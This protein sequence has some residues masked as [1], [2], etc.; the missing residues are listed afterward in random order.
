MVS[1]EVFN[2]KDEKVAEISS[3]YQGMGQFDLLPDSGKYTAKVQYN[4]KEYKFELPK[5]LL[6]GYVM[7]VD[8]LH[9]DEVGIQIESNSHFAGELLGISISS[10]GVL[11]GSQQ[12][13]MS[14][15]HAASFTF[16]KKMLPSGVSQI[17]LFNAVGVVLSERLIFVNH[18]SQMKMEMSQSKPIYR[19]FE[20]VNLDFKLKDMRGN[21]VETT[22]SVA[23]RDA[24]TSTTN[25]YGNNILTDL[26]LSSEV[27][28]YIE[29]PEYYFEKEN[30]THRMALDLLLLT[31]GWTRYV[32][33]EMAGVTPL[34]INQPVEKGLVMVGSV[35][36]LFL[37]KKMKD[38]DITMILISDSISQ[39]G[40]CR[41][42]SVGDFNFALQEFKGEAKLILQSK[43]KN[44]RKEMQIRL[45]RNFS[46]DFRAYAFPDLNTVQYFKAVR[47]TVL[48]FDSLANIQEDL[49]KILPKNNDRL[50]MDK[51]NHLLKEVTV[52]EKRQSVK[53]GIKYDFTK[54]LDRKRDVGEWMP[55]SLDT[56]LY[57]NVQY[58][59]NGKYK[60]KKVIFVRD[61]SKNIVSE[62]N[63]MIEDSEMS[64]AIVADNEST[65][66]SDR[67]NIDRMPSIDEIESISFIEDFSSVIRLYNGY[68]AEPSRT[69]IALIHCKKNYHKEP[70]GIRNTTFQGYAYTKEFFQPNYD[71]ALLPDEKDYRRTLYWNPDVKT[72]ANGKA[73]ISFFNNSS[74]KAM[75]VSAE[76][77]T[78][79][80]VIGA[81]CK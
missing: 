1:G 42:D 78:E 52:K 17:T 49:K 35:V 41:T 53:V 16:P 44:K 63:P 19:P 81:M 50:P 14:S 27:K 18:H 23:V 3:E 31:Q 56:Y 29:H 59:T 55:A 20:K 4:N 69:V 8:N 6:S 30:V 12:V 21:P 80:G 5:A 46:P 72:D 48:S 57:F 79:R 51:R 2:S 60:G 61:D 7:S 24:S 62:Y 40:T 34:K 76:T 32:W 74:C 67:R 66:T 70:Y 68:L 38:T 39:H 13:D 22:F 73:T 77:V 10:R 28:G 15:T 45:N 11:F 25:L 65:P 54:E 36:S 64:D 33:K 9:E 71:K 58:Y 47:D 75:N 26:L 43:K 37:G